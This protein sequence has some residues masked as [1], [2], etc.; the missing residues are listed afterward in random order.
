VAGQA[1]IRAIR[2]LRYADHKTESVC[3]SGE[4]WIYIKDDFFG[5]QIE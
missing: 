5:S 1:L 2:A 3:V 4:M